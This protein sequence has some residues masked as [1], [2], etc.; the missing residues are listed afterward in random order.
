MSSET[1]PTIARVP[2]KGRFNSGAHE[3]QAAGPTDH[4]APCP[5]LNIMANHGYIPRD[6]KNI[7]WW[8]IA[9]GFWNCFGVGIDI[10]GPLLFQV[11]TKIKTY[12]WNLH[13]FV[14]SSFVEHPASLTREDAIT[15]ADQ[16]KP[17]PKLV[18]ELL[19]SARVNEKGE[20]VIGLEEL[21]LYRKKRVDKTFENYEGTGQYPFRLGHFQSIA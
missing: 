17:D 7:T 12:P 19:A 5:A 9:W 15:G 11:R 18:E 16:T 21:A 14:P 8:D 13:D 20:K 3:F 6:G 2:G 4:R 10:S 1:A